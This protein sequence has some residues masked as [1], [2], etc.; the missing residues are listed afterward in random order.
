MKMEYWKKW[1][2]SR[3]DINRIFGLNYEWNIEFRVWDKIYEC[4]NISQFIKD[5]TIWNIVRFQMISDSLHGVDFRVYDKDVDSDWII[6]FKIQIIDDFLN[7]NKVICL[8]KG[9]V[10][11]TNR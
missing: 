2:I 9:R 8:L 1:M 6:T 3:S 4:V 10:K 5:I 7:R 11:R